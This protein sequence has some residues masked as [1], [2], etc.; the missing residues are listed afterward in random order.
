MKHKSIDSGSIRFPKFFLVSLFIG[1]SFF[2]SHLNAQ[3]I[4]T[5]FVSDPSTVS[6]YHLDN[7]SNNPGINVGSD[8]IK[9]FKKNKE[10]EFSLRFLGEFGK[11]D[12]KLNSYQD[13]PGTDR[14]LINDSYAKND[15][16]TIQ[17][18]N[19]IPLKKGKI[20]GGL[21]GIIRRANSNFQSLEKYNEGSDYKVD[22]KKIGFMGFSAGGT[23]TMSVVYNA[24]DENRPNFAAPLIDGTE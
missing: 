13:N 20:E 9:H 1:L 2:S 24:T 12:S 21:K 3:T 7:K 4:T 17:A 14:Y 23:V 16:Y 18:D 11:S 10:R 15:Q 22:P 5:D 6:L 8:Y 19:S